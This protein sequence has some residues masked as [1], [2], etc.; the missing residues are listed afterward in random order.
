M[1]LID[2][3]C[4]KLPVGIGSFEE[5]HRNGF[6]YVDKVG[7]IKELLENWGKAKFFPVVYIRLKD[8]GT[9]SYKVARGMAIKTINQETTIFWFL[10]K[11]YKKHTLIFIDEY[12]VSLAKTNEQDYYEKIVKLIHSLP[13][14]VLK[15]NENLFLLS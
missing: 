15:T 2:W 11:H 12:D 5:I 4:K 14:T 6:Y 13:G 7:L 3:P 10:N 8:V 9:N 1:G